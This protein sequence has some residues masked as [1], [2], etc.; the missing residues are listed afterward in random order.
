MKEKIG[1]EFH[2][3]PKGSGSHSLLLIDE[4]TNQKH[5]IAPATPVNIN[6]LVISKLQK[7]VVTL[8][9][10]DSFVRYTSSIPIQKIIWNEDHLIA[11]TSDKG[12][13][14]AYKPEIEPTTQIFFTRDDKR[15]RDDNSIRVWEGEYAPIEF[16]KG[17]LI[18]F[19]KAHT[20][21]AD[22]NL[23]DSIKNMK[24]VDRASSSSELID[25]GNGEFDD[26]NV[27]TVEEETSITNIPNKFKLKLPLFNNYSA[28]FYFEAKVM[29]S[30]SNSYDNPLK[31]KR[32]IQLRVV[33]ARE[34]MRGVMY[35]ILSKLPEGIPKYYGR[36]SLKQDD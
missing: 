7:E 25:L 35:D 4:Q 12:S 20:N 10:T 36:M 15:S 34:V 29:R 28:D 18:K 23:V 32:I 24:V 8:G 19:L 30:E 5:E 27:R 9:D 2:P 1:G 11:I 14:I 33:N 13:I 21:Q 16:T 26:A 17:N 31:G 3:Q 6:T 22:S